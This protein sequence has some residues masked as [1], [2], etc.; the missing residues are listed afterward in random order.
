MSYTY[1]V[2]QSLTSKM[3]IKPPQSKNSKLTAVRIYSPSTSSAI[4]RSEANLLQ[5]PET[6]PSSCFKVVQLDPI[7]GTF[8]G[9]SQSF[10]KGSYISSTISQPKRSRKTPQKVTGN[11]GPCFLLGFFSVVSGVT[12]RPPGCWI[13]R[14]SIQRLLPFA[15]GASRQGL[16][17]DCVHKAQGVV[18]ESWCLFLVKIRLVWFKE[19]W[20]WNCKN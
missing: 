16:S 14:R 7:F 15:R 6:L 9:Q 2:M 1:Q 4:A 18:P 20:S 13:R 8:A 19:I 12:K 11:L 5:P 10:S 17:I 3:L